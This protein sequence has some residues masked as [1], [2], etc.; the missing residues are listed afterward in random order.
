MG[1]P[2]STLCTQQQNK[3]RQEGVRVT[4]WFQSLDEQPFIV[5]NVILER[6]LRGT[7]AGEE[8]NDDQQPTID[9]S[10]IWRD[11]TRI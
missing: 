2:K 5:G 3:Q 11:P 8:S 4:Y 1:S 7:R 9:T 10:T 6:G